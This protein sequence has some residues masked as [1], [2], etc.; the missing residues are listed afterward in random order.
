MIEV[1]ER[2]MTSDISVEGGRYQILH[3]WSLD[4]ILNAMENHYIFLSQEET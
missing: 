1:K 3:T 4:F 2:R